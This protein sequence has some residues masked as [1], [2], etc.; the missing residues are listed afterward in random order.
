MPVYP[1][2][3]YPV[4]GVPTARSANGTTNDP[5]S[6]LISNLASFQELKD[7]VTGF[8]VS[9]FSSGFYFTTLFDVANGT[10]PTYNSA[11]KY[12]TDVNIG[13]AG[14]TAL[15]NTDTYQDFVT[16]RT[17]IGTVLTNF[18]TA[19]SSIGATS[20]AIAVALSGR[21]FNRIMYYMERMSFELNQLNG[22]LT[23][24]NAGTALSQ[25]FVSRYPSSQ[26][27]FGNNA[28]SL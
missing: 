6:F 11:A 14:T 1:S 8:G 13:G 9:N 18:D 10:A 3:L 23:R 25:T 15:Q 24:C 17:R 20:K 22:D 16:A 19:V 7:T 4:N 28:G 12:P 21:P 27:R 2:S 26:N 5:G